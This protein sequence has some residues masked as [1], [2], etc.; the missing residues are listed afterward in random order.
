M[1]GRAEEALRRDGD[2]YH[3]AN[4]DGVGTI[5]DPAF[6][7]I[8]LCHGVS[9]VGSVLEVGCSTGFRLSKVAAELGARVAGL[10]ASADAVDE[11]R[12]LHPGLDIRCGVAP[13][14]LSW[15]AGERFDVVV[16]GHLLYLQPREALFAL[17]AA[18]DG[19]LA[20]GGHLIVEDFLSPSPVSVPYRHDDTLRVFKAD[21]SAP[22]TWSPTYQLVSRTVYGIAVGSDPRFSLSSGLPSQVD[23]MAWQTLDVVRKLDPMT[24]YPE[25]ASLP[26][27]HDTDRRRQ[28]GA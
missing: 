7:Q 24:A 9:P 17:A 14:D 27:V 8:V 5:A 23:P 25:R 6:D 15:W 21:P 13:R 2:R 28:D 11:G 4:H 16:V 26:S 18:V 19:L 22:W 20:D 10:E 12:S 3:R 1:D